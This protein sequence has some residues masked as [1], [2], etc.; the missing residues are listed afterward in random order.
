MFKKDPHKPIKL[1]PMKVKSTTDINRG[2]DWW[3]KM[4]DF[5][6]EAVSPVGSVKTGSIR[7]FDDRI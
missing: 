5:I 7:R 6:K 4:K 3:T 1:K 2:P